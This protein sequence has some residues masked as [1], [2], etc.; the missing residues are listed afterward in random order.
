MFFV[1]DKNARSTNK[2][3]ENRLRVG[4]N[5]IFGK[6]RANTKSGESIFATELLLEVLIAFVS[7]SVCSKFKNLI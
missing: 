7:L 2:E 5:A 1:S 6:P 3:S 4:K